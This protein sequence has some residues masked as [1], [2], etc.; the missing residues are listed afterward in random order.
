MFGC[1]SF[2]PVAPAG[3]NAFSMFAPQD[4][5]EQFVSITPYSFVVGVG[6]DMRVFVSSQNMFAEMRQVMAGPKSS[7][8]TP[9]PR[10]L[11]TPASRRSSL[12]STVSSDSEDSDSID[13]STIVGSIDEEEKEKKAE[14]SS[15]RSGRLSDIHLGEYWMKLFGGFRV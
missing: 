12:I 14:T 4:P 15:Q 6:T 7:P 10:S 8:P 3:P 1:T 2:F 9:S 5:R 13:G 11:P